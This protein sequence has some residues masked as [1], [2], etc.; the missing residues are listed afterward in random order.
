MEISRRFEP[1]FV[2]LKTKKHL[3]FVWSAKRGKRD[4]VK[5]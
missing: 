1:F 5:P 2:N 4:G 3:H